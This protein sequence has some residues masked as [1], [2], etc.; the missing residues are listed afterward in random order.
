MN[1][2]DLT[3]GAYRALVLVGV[4][5]QIIDE[6]ITY[7]PVVGNAMRKSQAGK[8]GGRGAWGEGL[9]LCTEWSGRSF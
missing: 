4:I 1:K 7:L 8:D 2:T 9:L 6:I 5:E 3:W